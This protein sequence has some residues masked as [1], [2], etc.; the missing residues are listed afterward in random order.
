MNKYPQKTE[1]PEWMTKG[2]TT[3]IQKDPLKGTALNKYRPMTCLPMIWK[4]PTAQIRQEIYYSLISRALF[5]D[6]Q[7]RYRKSTRGTGELLYIDQHILKESKTWRKNLAIAWVE[8]KKLTIWSPKAGYYTVSK[9]KKIP[10]EAI[11][12]LEKNIETWRVELTTGG[13]SL[14]EVEDPEEY[15]TRRYAITTTICYRDDA[16]RSHSQEMHWWIHTW[17]VPFVRYSGPF[18][19]WTKEEFKQVDQKTRKLKTMHKILHPR[20]DID[21]LHVSRKEGGRGLNSTEYSVDASIQR[22]EDYIESRGRRLVIATRNNTND[23]RT[24]E[25]K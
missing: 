25:Q 6:E 3:L 14:A 9:C 21:R 1:T 17:A 2:R 22:L 13:K 7:K 16:T 12:F 11:K 20:D 10:D 24:T 8:S 18:L 23:T 4:I 5:P 15:I 19:K